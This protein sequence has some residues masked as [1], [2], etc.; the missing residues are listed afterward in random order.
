MPWSCVNTRAL[1]CV[2]TQPPTLLYKKDSPLSIGCH[3]SFQYPMVTFKQQNCN[4]MGIKLGGTFKNL[5]RGFNDKVINP[6][7]PIPVVLKRKGG[8]E[9]EGERP[10]KRAKV[11]QP[12]AAAILV[13]QEI[14]KGQ[15]RAETF[16]RRW[17]GVQLGAEVLWQVLLSILGQQQFWSVKQQAK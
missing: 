1:V 2:N 17:F 6:T 5:D 3:G 4:G 7:A 14:R 8:E 13:T 9:I 11:K 10:A 15:V 16:L 12:P